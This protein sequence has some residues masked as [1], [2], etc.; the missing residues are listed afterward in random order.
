MQTDLSRKNQLGIITEEELDDNDTTEVANTIRAEDFLD[1][2][3]FTFYVVVRYFVLNITS[4]LKILKSH[5]YLHQEKY[6]N[7]I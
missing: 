3:D 1:R 2:V 4:Y 6:I 5:L 7:L